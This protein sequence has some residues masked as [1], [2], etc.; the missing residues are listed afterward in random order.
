DGTTLQQLVVLL[1]T[2]E[3]AEEQ[4]FQ[5]V[6]DVIGPGVV[7]TKTKVLVDVVDDS[8]PNPVPLDV[9]TDLT[10]PRVA[11]VTRE[12]IPLLVIVDG[13]IGPVPLSVVVNATFNP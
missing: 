3:S 11:T 4:V 2:V 12:T 10:G 7:V 9:V 8:N 6:V 1:V 13:T 5:V